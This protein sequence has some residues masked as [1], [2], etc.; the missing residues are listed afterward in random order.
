MSTPRTRKPNKEL[1]GK[2]RG[3]LRSLAHELN[4]LVQIGK[5]GLSE[6]VVDAVNQALDDHELIKVRILETSPSDRR[7]IA[8]PLAAATGSHVVG[9]VGRIIMLYRMHD[10]KPVIEIPRR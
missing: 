2:Q 6:G 1:S 5:E 10:E 8:P 4:P 9:Q 3:H 7:E